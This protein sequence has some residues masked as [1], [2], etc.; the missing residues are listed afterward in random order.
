MVSGQNVRFAVIN[1]NKQ[2]PVIL[3]SI[4]FIFAPGKFYIGSLDQLKNI[5]IGLILTTGVYYTPTEVSIDTLTI[6]AHYGSYTSAGVI[7]C[8]AITA[9]PIALYGTETVI[10]DIGFGN[11]V[12]VTDEVLRTDTLHN[13]YT[14]DFMQSDTPIYIRRHAIDTAI[15]I[16]SC[17][18][19]TI[20][21]MFWVG[22]S[23]EIV[24]RDI[25]DLPY[26]MNSGDVLQMPFSIT[27]KIIGTY[28][29]YFIIHTTDDDYLVW[30]FEYRVHGGNAVKSFLENISG[31]E[32][33]IAANP[34][35]GNTIEFQLQS[36]RTAQ[37]HLSL[38]STDGRIVGRLHDQTLPQGSTLLSMN[39]NDL[40]NGMY[41]LAVRS[42][43]G[44]IL[45]K[46]IISR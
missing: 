7:I 30:S 5:P 38:I 10:E 43:I 36:I 11:E 13:V 34:V 17:G 27:P 31:I 23:T 2:S 39:I 37:I 19:R 24:I 3:D 41:L 29:H 44:N 12:G 46:I 6:I 45:R 28:P 22:D 20:D 8:R 32:L 26:T 14:P 40:P 15:T 1:L 25:P 21:R 16:K 35:S 18:V 4:Q 42:E 33:H 9:P